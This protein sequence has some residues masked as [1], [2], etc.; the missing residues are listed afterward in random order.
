SRDHILLYSF[1]TR[2]SSDLYFLSSEFFTEEGVKIDKP[3][4]E[5]IDKFVEITEIEDRRYVEDHQ[6]NSDIGYE[7]AKKALED[8]AINPEE[9]SEE[10]TSELQ[11]RENLVCR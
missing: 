6:M 7:A 8:A 5:I 4:A 9:R 11:S 2:R 1:P 3:T 10:H